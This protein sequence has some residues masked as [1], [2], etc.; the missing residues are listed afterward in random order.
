MLYYRYRET[1][2]RI[3]VLQVRDETEGM[4]VTVDGIEREDRVIPLVDDKLEHSVEVRMHVV[5][6]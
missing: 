2:Y 5:R 3:A 1:V 4:A 6:S